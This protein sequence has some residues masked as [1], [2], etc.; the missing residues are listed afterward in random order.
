MATLAKLREELQASAKE[1]QEYYELT[2]N[3]LEAE[4]RSG[5]TKEESEHHKQLVQKNSDLQERVERAKAAAIGAEQD[6]IADEANERQEQERFENRKHYDNP[7]SDPNRPISD[8]ER[9]IALEHW[10][11]KGNKSTP[12]KLAAVKRCRIDMAQSELVVNFDPGCDEASGMTYG[13]PK[14]I[15]EARQLAQLRKEA[16]DKRY[17]EYQR[18]GKCLVQK[19]QQV[20]GTDNLGGY[21]V[22]DSTMQAI[23]IALLQW[24]GMRQV[25]DVMRT[26]TGSDMPFPTTD[27]TGNVA[28]IVAESGAIVKTD[29]AFG[30]MV[31]N[32]FKY[33]TYVL[34]S[35]ELL[36]DSATNIPALMG[37]LLG[38]RIGRG[39]NAHFTTG[40]GT[41]EPTG[42][43]TA[44]TDSTV[45]TAANT[46]IT[47]P[48][49]FALKHSVDPAYR[50]NATWMMHDS[51][52][53]QMKTM[54][55]G[56]SRPLWQPSIVPGAPGT[57]DG[58][59]IQINQDMPVAG[60]AAQAVLYGDL[61]K[62]IIRD[63]MPMRL[64][65]L[66]ELFALNGQVGFLA[67]SRHD[68]N[69]LDAGTNPVKYLTLAT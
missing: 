49:L 31:L 60:T 53:L 41:T 20:V 48:E 50:G 16:V 6:K 15:T 12:E 57:L 62:Y 51:M 18:Y 8:Y 2:E 35:W 61:R 17:A 47:Y 39:T 27:D 44:A 45:V 24:G 19:R 34:V 30:Q 29:V 4:D 1:V 69:L 10:L 43:L 3:K 46:A 14:T 65:R 32:S 28:A 59:P 64:R 21:T 36:Q 56:E 37:R 68:G 42:I 54:V 11:M 9:S 58:D 63:V 33:G 5:W 67:W 23:E 7:D 52:L 22:P 26:A 13:A 25:S 40:A 66:D 38:E 55:D